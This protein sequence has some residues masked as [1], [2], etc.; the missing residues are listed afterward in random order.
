MKTTA[1]FLQ[2][3]ENKQT[4]KYTYYS[5]WSYFFHSFLDTLPQKS[6]NAN[7]YL[8][9]YFQKT[10]PKRT[11]YRIDPRKQNLNGILEMDHPL[12]SWQKEL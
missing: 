5:V 1:T 7:F 3:Q 9:V 12:G 2:K 8:S 4:I 10:W 11:G 6:M